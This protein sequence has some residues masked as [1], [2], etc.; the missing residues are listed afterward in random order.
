VEDGVSRCGTS[1]NRRAAQD[2]DGVRLVGA[3]WGEPDVRCPCVKGETTDARLEPLQSRCCGDDD[4]ERCR[5][6]I[7]AGKGAGSGERG[8]RRWA[9]RHLSGGL[10]KTPATGNQLSGANISACFVV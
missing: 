1:A 10:V 2:G 7:P 6:T 4:S 5:D 9:V 8:S 3:L